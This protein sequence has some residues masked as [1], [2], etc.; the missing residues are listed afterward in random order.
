MKLSVNAL[1]KS[2]KNQQRIK[3]VDVIFKC[4]VSL[5]LN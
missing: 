5:V 3:H 4:C 2:I 1:K